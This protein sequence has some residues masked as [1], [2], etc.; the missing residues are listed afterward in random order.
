MDPR[1]VD[2]EGERFRYRLR[3][4]PDNALGLVKF[5][6]PNRYNVYL[7]DTPATHLFGQPSRARSHGC[8]R[9]ER[10]AALAETL[11]RD[12]EWERARVEGALEADERRIVRLKEPMPVH[13]LY[14][15]AWVNADGVVQFRRDIYG[16][17]ARAVERLPCATG[18]R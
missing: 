4:G 15:T 10:P 9:V 11:L 16:R 2:W 18:S 14:L 7:H 8:V 1:A 5:M 12:R 3:P 6:F 17:D 13:L